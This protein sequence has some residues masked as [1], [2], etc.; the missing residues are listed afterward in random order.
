MPAPSLRVP[1]QTFLERNQKH[2]LIANALPA[3][4]PSLQKALAELV[5][6]RLFDD[7]QEAISG[8]A[9]RLACGTPYQDGTLP[10]LLAPAARSTDGARRLFEFHGRPRQKY[11]KWSL[12]KYIN[13]TTKFVIDPGDHFIRACDAHS[14]LISEMQSVRNRIAH[15][16]AN[17]RLKFDVV[18]R[19]YYGGAP[20]GVSPGLLLLT[21]RATPVPLQAYLTATRVVVRECV[22]A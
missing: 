22:K 1:Y 8:I 2:T 3:L 7:F 17:S 10:T 12:V 19:R 6:I 21:P 11:V 14:L 4:D 9:Y 18:L 15:R 5:L 20:A 16:N 13:E